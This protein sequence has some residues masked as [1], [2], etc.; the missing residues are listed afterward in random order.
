MSAK[1]NKTINLKCIKKES[2]AI[3]QIETEGVA[4]NDLDSFSFGHDL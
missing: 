2:A 4:S 1:R 3:V